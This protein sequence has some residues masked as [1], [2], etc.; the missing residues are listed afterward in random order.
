MICRLAESGLEGTSQRETKIDVLDLV[1]PVHLLKRP[2]SM[3]CLERQ[4]R[5]FRDSSKH[6]NH[7]S[8][9]ACIFFLILDFEISVIPGVK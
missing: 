9:L 6:K 5:V 2:W 7:Y 8:I 4:L 1:Q 3:V